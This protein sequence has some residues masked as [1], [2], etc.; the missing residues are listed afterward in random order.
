VT[1]RVG[2][3]VLV[4]DGGVL[5][6]DGGVVGLGEVTVVLAMVSACGTVQELLMVFSTVNCTPVVGTEK[7]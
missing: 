6:D 4:D 1:K 5:D 7:A 3:G 2:E